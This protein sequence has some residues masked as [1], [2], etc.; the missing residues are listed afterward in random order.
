MFDWQKTLDLIKNGLLEPRKAWE[1][2]H[3]ENL[4]WQSTAMVLTLPLVVVTAVLVTILAWIFRSQYMIGYGGGGLLGLVLGIIFSLV[5]IAIATFVFSY[6]AGVFKGKHD[7][8]RGLAA[9]SLAAIPANAGSILGTLP[10]IG[11]ILSI[12]LG[13]LGLV[14]L[15][16]LIPLYFEVPEDKRIVHFIVS[17]IVTFVVMLIVSAILGVGTI[18][19]SSRHQAAAMHQS[20][21]GGSSILGSIG[22]QANLVDAADKDKFTPPKDGRITDAQMERYLSV[23]RKTASLRNEQNEQL[24]KL[25]QDSKSGKDADISKVASGIG[26]LLGAATAEMEVVKTG[27]GNWAEHEWVKQQLRVAR[28][29]KDISDA[30]KSNYALYQKNADELQKIGATP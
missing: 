20:G 27:G 9:I 23:M 30:V 7:I 17:L 25:E 16:K 21:V 19:M 13:I 4:G 1:S 15:Y 6:L 29:Q 22:R 11:W 3:K 2:F 26:T 14:Y 28:I 10:W 18:G 8:N 5:G 12:A 24:K